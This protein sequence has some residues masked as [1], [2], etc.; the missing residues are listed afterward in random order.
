MS[1]PWGLQLTRLIL[2]SD[3]YGWKAPANAEQ[4]WYTNYRI[5][6][7][8]TLKAIIDETM[9][10][11]NFASIN[12]P[13]YVSYYYKDEAHQDNVVSVKRMKEMFEQVGTPPALKKE[14]ALADAGTHIIGSDL[15]NPNLASVWS[16]LIS[17]CED[18]LHLIPVQDVDWK[19]FIDTRQNN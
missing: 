2:G 19:P 1:G 16:P 14:V 8:I 13:I 18:V 15:F 3:F 6:G 7:I 12:D 9:T 17:Y 11:E 4:Y 10:K 5:E